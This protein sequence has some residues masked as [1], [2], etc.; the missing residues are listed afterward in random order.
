MKATY[1]FVFFFAHWVGD[2]LLQTSDMAHYKSTSIKWLTFHVAVYS[3]ALLLF[4]VWLMDARSLA[5]FVFSNAM[6]HWITDFFT[7]RIASKYSS[8]PRIFYSVIGFDQFI[9]YSTLVLT[10]YWL[11]GS[12]Q[13]WNLD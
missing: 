12:N 7:S 2:F 9:H 4:S 6:L 3:T 1:L 13:Q 10:S 5:W 8:R 11:L